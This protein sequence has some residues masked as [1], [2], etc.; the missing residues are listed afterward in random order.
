[1]RQTGAA[2]LSLLVMLDL[3]TALRL[4]PLAEQEVEMEKVPQ[5]DMEKVP[6]IDMDRVEE[7]DF[8]ADMEFAYDPSIKMDKYQARME[9]D[10]EGQA[11]KCAAKMAKPILTEHAMGP[12]PGEHSAL[13]EGS[14]YHTAL[15]A[16]KDAEFGCD[17]ATGHCKPPTWVLARETAEEQKIPR[18][19]WM[20]MKSAEK[21]GPFQY[22]VMADHWLK[23]PEYEFILSD[24]AMS[25]GFMASDEVPQKTKDAYNM[26]KKGAMRADIWRYAVMDVYGGVYMDQDMTA[27]SA[28]R[29]FVPADANVFQATINKGHGRFEASQFALFSTPNHPLWETTMDVVSRNLVEQPKANA[30]HITGPAALA[31][32]Y[33]ELYSANGCPELRRCKGKGANGV[34][35][36]FVGCETM[37]LGKVQVSGLDRDMGTGNRWHKVDKC[38]LSECRSEGYKHWFTHVEK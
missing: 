35:S 10:M 9:Y 1:M 18:I 13:R 21:S 30:L 22:K 25:D 15:Q 4:A 6:E 16:H 29:E 32:A 24:D 3:T 36:E 28:L 26:A 37:A 34:C 33:I 17:A 12:V 38:A 5:V 7:E 19:I 23:N 2:I 27:Q 31:N 11:K 8:I 20:T 14:Y